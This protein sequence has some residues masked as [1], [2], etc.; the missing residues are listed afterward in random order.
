MHLLGFSPFWWRRAY[1]CFV[2]CQKGEEI[3]SRRGW[4]ILLLGF[5]PR[6]SL[7]SAF[8]PA[9]ALSLG[10]VPRLY[11]CPVHPAC[12]LLCLR[13]W[14]NDQVLLVLLVEFL[15]N[16]HRNRMRPPS[17]HG[18]GAL[19]V[20]GKARFPSSGVC[21]R[22]APSNKCTVFR[23]ALVIQPA[24]V[25]RSEPSY[26]GWPNRHQGYPRGSL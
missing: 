23:A 13:F 24:P 6:S 21:N 18:V 8:P 10:S 9:F 22:F 19:N 17:H 3:S 25:A 5:S 16:V 20:F 2:F 12:G 7:L 14:L 11:V 1:I 15:E 26:D 4:G